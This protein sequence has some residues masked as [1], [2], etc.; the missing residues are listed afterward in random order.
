MTIPY[1]CHQLLSSGLIKYNL[2]ILI[3][4]ITVPVTT[5][6]FTP[7]GDNNVVDIEEGETQ[8][9]TCYTDHIRPE[10][11]IQWYIGVQNVTDHATSHPPL[12][13]DDKFISYSILIYK[14]RDVDH[15]KVIFCE[16]VNIEGRQ[17]IKSAETSLNI[18]C[19]LLFLYIIWI[20]IGLDS[21]NFVK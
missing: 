17:K 9:F 10:A 7:G 16:A 18:L 15:S 8:P 2:I 21:I 6:T 1:G 20:I 4:N 12:Q 5:V 19:K 3:F 11:W 14:G 13:V